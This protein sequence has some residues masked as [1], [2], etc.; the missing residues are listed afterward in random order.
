MSALAEAVSLKHHQVAERFR[1]FLTAKQLEKKQ[2][3]EGID[4]A[5]TTSSL[6]SIL[7]GNRKPSRALAV[8]IERT[9]GFRAEF[10]L[11]GEGEMWSLP[12]SSQHSHLS[13]DEENIIQFMRQSVTNA[14]EVSQSKE[15]RDLWNRVNN[16]R[17]RVLKELEE[18]AQSSNKEHSIRY[19]MLAQAA[20]VETQLILETYDQYVEV[21]NARRSHELLTQFVR[22]YLLE[23]SRSILNYNEWNHLQEIIRPT[24]EK[25]KIELDLLDT[26]LKNLKNTLQNLV[27]MSLPSERAGT[28]NINDMNFALDGARDQLKKLK[29]HLH[30][31]RDGSQ[32]EDIEAS[33]G[34]IEMQLKAALPNHWPG[35][36]DITRRLLSLLKDQSELI[37]HKSTT[38]LNDYFQQQLTPVMFNN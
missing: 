7:N 4:H 22:R 12:A 17:L 24:L 9:W 32:G 35:M 1:Y 38:E 27:S 15:I 10:L 29:A 11:K 37:P 23:F 6:F 18:V 34:A 31:T 36:K 26:S 28:L 21:F 2:F 33:I 14:R 13:E 20:F 19:P 16:R 30:S 5:I 3:L 8:L 25:R